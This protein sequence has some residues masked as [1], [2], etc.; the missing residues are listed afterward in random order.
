MNLFGTIFS[1]GLIHIC[2]SR[3]YFE[4]QGECGIQ[5]N[6]RVHGNEETCVFLIVFGL[7]WNC[8]AQSNKLFYAWDTQTVVE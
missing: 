4:Q 1:C 2:C 8:L 7:Q 3:E 6:Y 5:I